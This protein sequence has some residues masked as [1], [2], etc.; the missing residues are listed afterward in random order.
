MDI[1]IEST[2]YNRQKLYDKMKEDDTFYYFEGMKTK[3]REYSDVEVDFRQNSNFF[4]LTGIDLPN[5][6]IIINCYTKTM[7]LVTPI[8]NKQYIV[9]NGHIPD[10]NNI[11]ELYKF[12]DIT[13]VDKLEQFKFICNKVLIDSIE[14][15]RIIKN[16]YE[17]ILMKE[18]CRISSLIH[19]KIIYHKKIFLKK[20]ERLI[21]NYFIYHTHN[22]DNVNNLAY[23]P[24]ISSGINSSIIHYYEGNRIIKSRDTIIIDAGCEYFNYAS[25]ITTTFPVTR[26]D[27]YQ[28]IIYNIVLKCNDICKNN[29]KE[30]I[31]FKTLYI[32]ILNFIY[33]ELN[34]LRLI[35]TVN[36]KKDN[37]SNND[38]ARLLMPHILGHHIGLDVH[39]VGGSLYNYINN[40]DSGTILKTN[41]VITIEPGIY[42]IRKILDNNL[43]YFNNIIDY[44]HVGGVRIKDVV[45]VMKEGFEQLNQVI[46]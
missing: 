24:I 32:L 2:L 5:Y 22:F 41:M 21:S 6:G 29:I 13:T 10:F 42:F 19:N 18:A 30:G 28:N 46:R 16:D 7:I 33:D 9:W 27:K 14:K 23:L 43:K 31:D 40:N 38:I 37:K 17:I 11:K 3:T 34:K 4:W 45:V 44:Y 1:L 20:K 12:D 36:Q 26:F 39:D 35:N 8:Y 15:L 25:A